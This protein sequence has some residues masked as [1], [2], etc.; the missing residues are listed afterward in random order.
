MNNLGGGKKLELSAEAP[1]Q[2]QQSNQY[3]R[4]NEGSE[5]FIGFK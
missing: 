5:M 1:E 2:D 4:F 3:S